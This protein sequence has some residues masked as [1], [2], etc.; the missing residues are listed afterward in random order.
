MEA[1][2]RQNASRQPVAY[3]QETSS[4]Q[5]LEKVFDQPNERQEITSD[6]MHKLNTIQVSKFECIFPL[7]LE[8]FWCT[9][10]MFSASSI[11]VYSPIRQDLT[12][13]PEVTGQKNWTWHMAEAV[14]TVTATK[15]LRHSGLVRTMLDKFENTTLL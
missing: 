11:A 12:T 9:A 6:I 7:L 1:F 5:Q 8:Y 2:F 14:K 3:L 15:V 13:D 4:I 10:Q